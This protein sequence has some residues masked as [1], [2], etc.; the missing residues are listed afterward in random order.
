MQL[1]RVAG[2]LQR[3][4]SHERGALVLRRRARHLS[5][6]MAAVPG[7]SAGAARLV[8]GPAR[9]T[10]WPALVA[11][12]A[13]GVWQPGIGRLSPRRTP[14]GRVISGRMP[15]SKSPKRRASSPQGYSAPALEKGIDIIELLADSE[16]GLTVSEI[17]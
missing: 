17:S 2:G 6:A 4:G 14:C 5:R 1:P 15:T 8:Q 16:S 7:R 10:A 11:Q 9:R 12:P 3:G 13:V